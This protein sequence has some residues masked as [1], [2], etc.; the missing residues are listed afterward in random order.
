ME[1]VV[2]NPARQTI[3]IRGH[4]RKGKSEF[5]H[6]D[7][8]PKSSAKRNDMHSERLR[9]AER[10]LIGAAADRKELLTDDN[11]QAAMMAIREMLRAK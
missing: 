6:G 5:H 7:M 9:L 3:S 10:C 1:N 4:N 11:W 2:L 8:K